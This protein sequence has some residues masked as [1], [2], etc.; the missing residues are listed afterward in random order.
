MMSTVI[1]VH[2]YTVTT[3]KLGQIMWILGHCFEWKWCHDVMVEALHH[4][5]LLLTSILDTCKVFEHLSMMSPV[6]VHP[7]YRVTLTKLCQ[8]LASLGHCQVK[9][10]PS[11][12]GWGCRPLQIASCICIGNIL[13][14]WAPFNDVH[15][16]I[17]SP[18]HCYTNKVWSDF[19]NSGSLS[20]ENDAIIMSWLGLYGTGQLQI[21]SHIHIGHKKV[22]LPF[23]AVCSL[24]SA[25]TADTDNM[26][27]KVSFYFCEFWVTLS[28][29]YNAIMSWLRL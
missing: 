1:I 12:H 11:C 3:M 25:P 10:M 2:P 5:R 9:M 20:S 14:V 16:H 29:G 13:S 19:G 28:S 18:L 21:A 23:N 24:I 27:K 22:L 15:S 7:C 6:I 4:C 8:I 17:T 26:S